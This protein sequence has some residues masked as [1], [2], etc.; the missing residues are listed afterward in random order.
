M[1]FRRKTTPPMT[2]RTR[3]RKSLETTEYLGAARRFI[4]AAGRR[5]ADSD[6]IELAGLLAL[7]TTLTEALQLAVDG[8]RAMGKSWADIARATG[9]SPQAAH[10]CWGRDV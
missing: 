1:P 6:E 4:L 10:Q 3:S 2:R 8:Q 7:Q 5:V 9:K